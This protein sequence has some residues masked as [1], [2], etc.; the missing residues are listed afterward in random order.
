M[1]S[2]SMNRSFSVDD[3]VGGIFR[4]GQAGAGAFGRTDSEAAFQEFLKRIPSATNLAANQQFEPNQLQQ[5]QQL[6]S[7]SGSGG[8]AAAANL[9]AGLSEAGQ[10]TGGMPRVPSLDVLRQLVIQNQLSQ[11][12]SQPGIAK[13]EASGAVL[14]PPA[15]TQMPALSAP[16]PVLSMA[17]PAVD[18]AVLSAAVDPSTLSALGG[19]PGLAAA[20]AANPALMV[21]PAAAA[22]AALQ[23]QHLGGGG[24]LRMASSMERDSMGGMGGDKSENRRQRRM[25]SNRESA[26]RSRKRKQEHMQSLEMQIEDLVE[27][28]REKEALADAA[29][30]RCRVLEDENGR[31]REENERLRDELRFLRQ[32][33]TERKERN[34]YYRREQG[35][36]DDEAD[37]ASRKRQRTSDAA[38]AAADVATAA[39]AA[40]A[41]VGAD[42]KAGLEGLANGKQHGTGEGHPVEPAVE[43]QQP[44]PAAADYEL[45]Q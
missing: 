17:S 40:A 10:G 35:A 33:M 15:S 34:G 14:A 16:M 43:A 5:A 27:A 23:L 42:A 31:L 25:L 29:E 22:A 38:T 39:A 20:A 19:M 6:L 26:R 28:R 36:A 2:E 9:S 4:L 11:G 32:E 45:Q 7:A 13:A 18:P 44:V 24:H 3:L 12:L 1:A 37:E 8:G 21:N 30:R 41:A